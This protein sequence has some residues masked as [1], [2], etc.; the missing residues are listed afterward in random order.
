MIHTTNYIITGTDY[1]FA[2]MLKSC[3]AF[4]K[5]P[6]EFFLW[7]SCKNVGILLNHLALMWDQHINNSGQVILVPISKHFGTKD[8]VPNLTVQISILDLRDSIEHG[9][10]AAVYF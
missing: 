7:P 5:I 3:S 9:E 8:C 2:I 4:Y 10:E 6:E 1:H